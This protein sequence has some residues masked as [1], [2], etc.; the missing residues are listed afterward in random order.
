MHRA[1]LSGIRTSRD[2]NDMGRTN[3]EWHRA[4]PMPKT[5][6]R[7]QRIAWHREH[8]ANC[9]CREMPDSIAKL[10]QEDDARIARERGRD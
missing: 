3:A 7:A 8:A 1:G 2:L 9:A 4:H 10:I 6:T 5:P